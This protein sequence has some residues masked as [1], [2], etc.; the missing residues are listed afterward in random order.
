M[1]ERERVGR[2]EIRERGEG[3]TE[4]DLRLVRKWGDGEG[5]EREERG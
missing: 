1:R 5:V 2:R 4:N 3:K